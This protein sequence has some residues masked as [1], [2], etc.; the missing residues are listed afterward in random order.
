MKKTATL[1]T[2]ILILL[3]LGCAAVPRTTLA[4]YDAEYPAQEPA[5]A[6]AA[7]PDMRPMI[8]LTF[9]D[10]PSEH[11]DSILDVLKRYGGRATFFVMGYLVETW[12]DTIIRA[13]G[14]GNEIAGH[15]WSHRALPYLSRRAIIE[16]IQSTSAAIEKAAGIPSPFF[17]RPPYG[18]ISQRVVDVSADMGYA[19]VNWTLDTWDWRLR[20]A[21]LVYDAVMR[22]AAEGDIIL[23][24]DIHR[25]TAAAMQRVIPSL[26]A[27]G[28]RLV[29]VSE[30]LQHLYG[31]LEPGKIYGRRIMAE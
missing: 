19:I 31:G 16:T 8:A 22:A 3:L 17:F 5:I 15:T 29:T 27:A 11:T 12:Q 21:D 20:D 25:T 4:E 23:L 7:K 26:V 13:V 14:G 1:S 10:G 24:H 28:F 18:M 9:D 30:L 2:A 6:E